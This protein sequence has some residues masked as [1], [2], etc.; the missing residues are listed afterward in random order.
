MVVKLSGT[1]TIIKNSI[2]LIWFQISIGSK[3]LTITVVTIISIGR[4]ENDDFNL[5]ECIMK[6]IHQRRRMNVNNTLRAKAGP[7]Y[8]IKFDSQTTQPMS[9]LC[10]I[11]SNS[12]DRKSR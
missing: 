7:N 10:L 4:G 8:R 2:T 1:R 3:E 9:I 6:R 5:D 12:R 11:I